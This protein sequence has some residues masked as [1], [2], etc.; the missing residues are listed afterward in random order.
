MRML[1][2]RELEE[3]QIS[4]IRREHQLTIGFVSLLA[5]LFLWL[6]GP[7]GFNIFK[8]T[9]IT[10]VFGLAGLGYVG[11][12]VNAS[13]QEGTHERHMT[14]LQTLPIHK[15]QIVHAKFLGISIICGR[16]FLWMAVF[17]SLNL[18]VN[19]NWTLAASMA[20]FFAASIM[21][22]LVAELLFLYYMWGYQK[23]SNG[24]YIFSIIVWVVLFL[25]GFVFLAAMSEQPLWMLALFI[26][27]L[28]VYV[29]CWRVSVRRI[30]KRGFVQEEEQPGLAKTEQWAEELKKRQS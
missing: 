26:F 19:S 3:M 18:I 17:I 13:L 20:T 10:P 4:P 14:F 5:I 27:S 11:M 15:S 1:I 9:A 12:M 6:L 2:K 23:W 21:L 16:T 28:V 7:A 22:L 24:V 30:Q 25:Y 29:L 8:T